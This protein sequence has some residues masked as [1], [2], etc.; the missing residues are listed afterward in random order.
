[1]YGG[2]TK[3]SVKAE[4]VVDGASA[5]GKASVSGKTATISDCNRGSVSRTKFEYASKSFP[6]DTS[7]A[8]CWATRAWVNGRLGLRS[9][10]EGEKLCFQATPRAQGSCVCCGWGCGYE[11]RSLLDEPVNMY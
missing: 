1:M 8:S 3:G 4:Q 11:L 10:S 2:G 6:C 5:E 9:S 7:I